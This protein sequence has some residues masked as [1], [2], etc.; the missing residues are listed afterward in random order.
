MFSARIL[1]PELELRGAKLSLCK[2]SELQFLDRHCI[3]TKGFKLALTNVPVC[4]CALMQ[5][6][7]TTQAHACTTPHRQMHEQS[8]P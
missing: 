5:Y 4:Q 3:A 8:H 1:R 7:G 6:Y 2:R